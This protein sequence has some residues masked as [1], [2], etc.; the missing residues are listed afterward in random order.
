MHWSSVVPME[1][2][3]CSSSLFSVSLM[4]LAA[5]SLFVPSAGDSVASP[6]SWVT[7]CFDV[8]CVW[9]TLV[10]V[11]GP[12]DCFGVKVVVCPHSSKAFVHSWA[13]LH[14]SFKVQLQMTDTFRACCPLLPALSQKQKGLL[15]LS[16]IPQLW[17][18]QLQPPH[19]CQVQSS[20]LP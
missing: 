12:L 3:S 17:T 4:P 20:P 10:V 13:W 2:G 8:L 11:P 15:P 16:G 5:L 1:C 18:W 9:Q 7:V 14:H 19:S 6:S